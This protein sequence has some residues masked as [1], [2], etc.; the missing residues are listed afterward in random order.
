M[1]RYYIKSGNP[2]H[3]EDKLYNATFHIKTQ[4]PIQAGKIPKNF[5]P[6]SDNFY[7]IDTFSNQ[8]GTVRGNIDPNV[9]GLISEVRIHIPTKT[10]TWIIISEIDLSSKETDSKIGSKFVPANWFYY[11]YLAFSKQ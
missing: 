2:E 5:I 9:T 3:P 4:R 10:D 8:L 6:T 7:I 1:I 11:Y